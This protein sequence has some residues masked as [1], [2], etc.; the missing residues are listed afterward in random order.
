MTETNLYQP[1]TEIIQPFFALVPH[2][3]SYITLLWLA[4]GKVLKR[5]WSGEIGVVQLPLA[6]GKE[7]PSRQY[8]LPFMRPLTHVPYP[9]PVANTLF[10]LSHTLAP[11]LKQSALSQ[12]LAVPKYAF[13]TKKPVWYR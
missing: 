4:A 6:F 11:P 2:L 8:I 12:C 9:S 7:I 5:K 1:T 13:D 10:Q 3:E